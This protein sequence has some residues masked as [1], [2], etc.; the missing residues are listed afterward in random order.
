MLDSFFTTCREAEERVVVLQ[1]I[2]VNLVN[3]SEVAVIGIFQMGRYE[4]EGVSFSAE[5]FF[6]EIFPLGRLDGEIVDGRHVAFFD[7][8][9]LLVDE[10]PGGVGVFLE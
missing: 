1:G 7:L 2:L 8:H 4:Q 10:R 6:S 5:H 9:V 3:L